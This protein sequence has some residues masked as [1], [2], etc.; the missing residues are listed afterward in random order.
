MRRFLLD[1]IADPGAVIFLVIGSLIFFGLYR[2]LTDVRVGA[3]IDDPV[4]DEYAPRAPLE[5]EHDARRRQL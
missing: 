5:P 3:L 2:M 4:A 1:Y